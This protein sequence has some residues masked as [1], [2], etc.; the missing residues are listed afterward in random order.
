MTMIESVPSYAEA[1][2]VTVM[3]TPNDVRR[4]FEQL[5]AED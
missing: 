5:M 1:D 4:H 3:R 2:A